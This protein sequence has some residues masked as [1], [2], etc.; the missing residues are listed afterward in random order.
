MGL[1]MTML[2]RRASACSMRV[3][4][5]PS[6]GSANSHQRRSRVQNLRHPVSD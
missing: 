6:T 2:W 5:P 1:T 3:D 4:A